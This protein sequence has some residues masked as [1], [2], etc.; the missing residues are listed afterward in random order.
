MTGRRVRVVPVVGANAPVDLE[1]PDGMSI[2]EAIT[3]AFPN[4]RGN[5]VIQ[6][7]TSR[8][9]SS[10]AQPRDG[11]ELRFMPYTTGGSWNGIASQS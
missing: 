7:E 2:G 4:V 6:D 9:I 1:L 8:P 5:V 11:Q 3:S 10:S